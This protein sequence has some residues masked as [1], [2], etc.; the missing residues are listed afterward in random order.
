MRLFVA[1]VPPE[2]I[3]RQLASLRDDIPRARWVPAERLHLTLRFLGEVA[4]ADLPG[5][6]AALA[7]VRHDVFE[8]AFSGVGRFG[9]PPRA[10]WAGVAPPEPLEALAAAVERAVQSVGLAP[11]D[12]PFAAHLTLARPKSAPPHRVRAWLEK[13]R[14]LS[15]EP[16]RVA[17]FELVE[18]Q[19]GREGPT[20]RTLRAF[21][22]DTDGPP[23]APFP[24]RVPSSDL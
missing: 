1:V 18:S 19:L 5:L 22:L 21:P 24:V 16:F 14:D 3:R 15:S 7:A 13:N 17:R 6:E 12:R 9:R 11:A 4:E 8:V 2:P 10:L 20:Y 23:S